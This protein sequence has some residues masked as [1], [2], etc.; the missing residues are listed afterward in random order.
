MSKRS[1]NSADIP[2]TD[3]TV[4]TLATPLPSPDFES[5]RLQL[6]S[7]SSVLA[8][9]SR[10]YLAQSLDSDL[11]LPIPLVSRKIK[12]CSQCRKHKVRC[13]VPHRTMQ[14]QCPVV[15]RA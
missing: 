7:Q 4:S 14:N 15:S 5:E 11:E 2:G 10:R 9:K 1:R 3:D 13:N 6:T 8:P 12:A